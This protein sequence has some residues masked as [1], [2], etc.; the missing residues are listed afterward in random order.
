MTDVQAQQAQAQQA[1][2]QQAQAQRAQAQ[3]AQAQA[4]ASIPVSTGGSSDSSDGVNSEIG[5]LR[6]E[7]DQY[8]RIIKTEIS[9]FES[10]LI[11]VCSNYGIVLPSELNDY[12]SKIDERKIDKFC[13]PDNMGKHLS[14]GAKIEALQQI[15]NIKDNI[16]KTEEGS[17]LFKQHA[18]KNLYGEM[19]DFA[20]ICRYYR[21]IVE[22]FVRLLRIIKEFSS[23]S[24][25]NQRIIDEFSSWSELNQK[26]T[27]IDI[28]GQSMDYILDRA[29]EKLG[30]EIRDRR[31]NYKGMFVS[32]GLN[33]DGIFHVDDDDD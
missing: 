9:K 26:F 27:G 16:M 18:T 13:I 10:D 19:L 1:Q 5:K 17:K 22:N 30:R 32:E 24:E 25:L 29:V 12:K 15:E 2:A 33:I 8:E 3:Q 21:V 28:G 23:L 20:I 4:Q 31:G 11:G 6:A 7:K 14:G